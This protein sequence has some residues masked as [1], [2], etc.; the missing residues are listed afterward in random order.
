[1][2]LN[3]TTQKLLMLANRVD[4]SL[5]WYSTQRMAGNSSRMVSLFQNA[6]AKH[7]PL[8]MAAPQL[9]RREAASTPAASTQTVARLSSETIR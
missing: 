9:R 6:M 2:P 3:A 8:P 5:C 1:M 4:G 7:A